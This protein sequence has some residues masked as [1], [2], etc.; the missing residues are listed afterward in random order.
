MQNHQ[1]DNLLYV[2]PDV[3]SA[4]L[5]LLIKSMVIHDTECPYWD[6]VSLNSTNQTFFFYIMIICVVF[7]TEKIAWKTASLDWFLFQR[8]LLFVGI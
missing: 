3:W 8:L 2:R 6:Q 7:I 1:A 5:H 4:D